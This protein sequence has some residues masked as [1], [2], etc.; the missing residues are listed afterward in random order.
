MPQTRSYIMEHNNSWSAYCCFTKQRLAHHGMAVSGS[1]WSS[2]AA[3]QTG[4]DM[5]A[6]PE[7]APST[8]TIGRRTLIASVG[9]AAAAVGLGAAVGRHPIGAQTDNQNPATPDPIGSPVPAELSQASGNWPVA[10]GDLAST[11]QAVGSA[12]SSASV[13]QLGVAWTVP[14]TVSGNFSGITANAVVLDGVV[15]LQDMQSN[16][17]ALDAATGQSLWQTN[18]DVPSNGPNGVALGYGMLYAATGDTSEVMALNPKTGEE[19][20]KIRLSFNPHECIDMAPAVYDNTVYISTNPNNVTNGNYH[21]GARGILYALDASNGSVI[22]SFDTSTDNLWGSPRLNSGAG[23]WYPPSIDPDGNLYFGTGNA[24]PYPGL[25][26]YPSGSSRPGPNDYACSMVSLDPNTGAVR[27][28]I[29]AAPHDLFDHDFQASPILATL[30]T[31]GAATLVSIG[32]GKTGTVIATRAD[33]GREIW[34]A[35]VGQHENDTLTELPEG[36]TRI[37]PGTLGGV[38]SPLA[39]STG[40][41]FVPYLDLAAYHTPTGAD[42]TQT[43]SINDAGGGLVAL[44]LADGTVKWEANLGSI[45][46]SGAT[47]SNDL[48]FAG[49]MNG[50]LHAYDIETGEDVW[51]MQLTAGLNAPP[52]IA[53]DLLLI[54]AGGPLFIPQNPSPIG[55]TPQ[56]I[57]DQQQTVNPGAEQPQL[58]PQIFALRLGVMGTSVTA[59]PV[60]TPIA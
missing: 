33:N 58:T 40:T 22:W 41:V 36:T 9:A 8:R 56:A 15:Y 32:S 45:C 7:R 50:I 53:G 25:P 1:E 51:N 35:A 57:S 39:Y 31:D 43:D 44:N 52:A 59:T 28:N 54:P 46:V 5:S 60:A 26:D 18:Y 37:V 38:N 21:G 42:E 19:I 48:V 6:T 20:W 49:G 34:R 29:N 55:G 14:I 27:W 13:A 23:M 2:W 30:T 4:N 11:R 3:T 47:V 16:V 12:I 17:F 24:G 10:Q